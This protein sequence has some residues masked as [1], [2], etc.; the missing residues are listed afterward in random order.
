VARRAG[1]RTVAK[2][3]GA[4]LIVT[5]A[6]RQSTSATLILTVFWNSWR[7]AS[8]ALL[9]DEIAKQF[10]LIIILRLTLTPVHSELMIG[11]GAAVIDPD[12][13]FIRGSIVSD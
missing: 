11:V 2:N 3:L 7:A 8:T 12:H 1:M 13:Q 9:I 4:V 5:M 6:G 10:A